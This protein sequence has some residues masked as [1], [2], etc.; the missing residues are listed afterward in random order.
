[1]R[2]FMSPFSDVAAVEAWDAWFRWR[3]QGRL[4][5]LAI[6]DTW[7]RVAHGLSLPGL[8]GWRVDFETRMVEAALNWRLLLDER[9]I[10]T[11]GTPEL[12]WTG[13]APVAALNAAAFVTEPFTDKARLEYD[14][15]EDTAELATVAL[16]NALQLAGTAEARLRI[17]LLGLA[18]ALAMLGCPYDSEAGRQ[19]A[20]ALARSLMHGC[21]RGSLRL[22]RERGA[23]ASL[24]ELPGLRHKLAEL[25]SE[26]SRDALHT[27]LRHVQLTAITSQRR[28][29]LLANNATDAVD[30]LLSQGYTHTISGAEA[31]RSVCSAGYALSLAIRLKRTALLEDLA[32]ERMAI[33]AEAQIAMRAAVQGWIDEAI[34]YPLPAGAAQEV[35]KAVAAAGLA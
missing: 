34:T 29:A 19:T 12:G 22:A 28:L 27:G 8:P 6:N 23:V 16:D 15:F 14:A 5:D 3:E 33:S 10:A 20:C 7:I 4:R 31:T 25:S 11:A 21:L 18:D 35:L 30:P 24:A 13:A 17:G 2:H 9:I 32:A 1:M 26:L